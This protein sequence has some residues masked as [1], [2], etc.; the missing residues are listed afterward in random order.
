MEKT[1]IIRNGYVVDP[2]NSFEGTADILIRDGRIEK[3][4]PHLE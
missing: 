3:V 2:A 4:G 1:R